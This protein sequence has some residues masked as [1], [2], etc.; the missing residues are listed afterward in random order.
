M[1][2]AVGAP[3]PEDGAPLARRGEVVA[4]ASADVEIGETL[5]IG[6]RDFRVVG[7]TDGATLFGGSP[8]VYIVL[9]YAQDVVFAGE[10]LASTVVVQGVPASGALPP[11]VRVMTTAET[12]RDALRVLDSAVSTIDLVRVLLWIVAITIMGSI[13]Y[14]STIERTRDIAVYRA[15]GTSTAAVAGGLALQAVLLAAGSSVVAVVLA[16]VLA[17]RFPMPAEIPATAFAVMPLIAVVVAL[18]ASV[19]AMR[20]AVSV[21]PALAFGG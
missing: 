14:L 17:P 11:E 3:I 8:N 20:R 12:K 6:G 13:L 16:L 15:T 19:A 1:P 5:I 21:Q 7:T 4:D 10:A 2:G 9:E 18:V